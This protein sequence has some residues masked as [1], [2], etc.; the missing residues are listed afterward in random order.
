MTVQNRYNLTDRRSED[1]LKACEQAGIGFMPWGPI[2]QGKHDILDAVLTE[3]ASTR[4]SITPGQMTLAWLLA[5]SPVMLPIPGTGSVA[6][7]EENMVAAELELEPDEI[8]AI[9]DAAGKA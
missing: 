4:G 7:L 9:G 5:H 6:H 2:S 1:V 3:A 8:S